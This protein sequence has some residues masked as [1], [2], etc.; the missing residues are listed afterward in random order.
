MVITAVV[1]AVSV[2]GR[3]ISGQDKYGTLADKPPQGNVAKC[4]FA[5]HTIVTKQ[6]DVF[7]EYP[8]R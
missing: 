1:L 5:C 3:A 6:D 8:K 4:G 7:T 2:G